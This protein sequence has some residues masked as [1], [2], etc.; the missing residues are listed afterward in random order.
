MSAP[1]KSIEGS[2]DLAAVMRDLGVRARAAARM[3]A[4]ASSAQKNAA[5]GC[6][7]S[8]LRAHAREIMVA[9][10]EDLAEAKAGGVTSAF[11]DRLALDERDEFRADPAIERDAFGDAAR[12]F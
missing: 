9:N 11:V 8:A 1:L 12:L 5:L 3:L 10:A 2:D 6:M 4:L 7:A